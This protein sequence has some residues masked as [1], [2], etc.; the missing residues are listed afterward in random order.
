MKLFKIIC[1]LTCVCFSIITANAFADAGER[2]KQRLYNKAQERRQLIN[3]VQDDISR[4]QDRFS[5]QQTMREM[6]EMHNN[7]YPRFDNSKAIKIDVFKNDLNAKI[8]SIDKENDSN[9]LTV[10]QEKISKVDMESKANELN[11]EFRR[12]Q[13]DKENKS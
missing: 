8:M 6:E 11:I 12:K 1:A 2:I 5:K 7:Y 13:L 10:L 3:R 4:V 9:T